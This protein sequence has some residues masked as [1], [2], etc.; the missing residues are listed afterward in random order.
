LTAAELL[1]AAAPEREE[2][3]AAP[4]VLEPGQEEAGR[5]TA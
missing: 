5:R 2:L 1:E 4:G 3:P